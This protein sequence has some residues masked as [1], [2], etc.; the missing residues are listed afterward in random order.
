MADRNWLQSVA[1]GALLAAG[2]LLVAEVALAQFVPSSES[3]SDMYPG[4]AY[5]PYAQR[6]FPGRVFWC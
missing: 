5:S 1:A 3:L 6:T 2:P 4:K